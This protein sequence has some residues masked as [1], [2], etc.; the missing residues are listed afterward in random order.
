MPDPKMQYTTPKKKF[1]LALSESLEIVLSIALEFR[2]R[3][4][5]TEDLSQEKVDEAISLIKDY[6]MEVK[7]K[8]ARGKAPTPTKP[9]SK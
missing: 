7:D 8:E 2:E 5:V 3:A 4:R 6:R 9:K 1:N